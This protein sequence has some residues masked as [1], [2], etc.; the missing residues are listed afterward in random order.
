MSSVLLTHLFN[1]SQIWLLS[2]YLILFKLR[3]ESAV[4]GKRIGSPFHSYSSTDEHGE[5][6]GTLNHSK[7]SLS[8]IKRKDL[9]ALFKQLIISQRE[10]DDE[11]SRLDTAPETVTF[12]LVLRPKASKQILTL[13]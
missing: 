5:K 10:S 4:T 6:R 11:K 8:T 2:K 7:T 13:K 12:W 1:F 9:A 3:E